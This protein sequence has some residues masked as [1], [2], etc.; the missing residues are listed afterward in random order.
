MTS[1]AAHTIPPHRR[2]R[3]RRGLIMPLVLIAMGISMILGLAFLSGAT[4]AS[5]TASAAAVWLNARMIA[6]SGI[7]VAL[8]QMD[9][10]P[11][12]RILRPNGTW[13]AAQPLGGGTF[14][15]TVQ[16]GEQLDAAGNV[17][18]DGSLSDD[19]QDPVVITCVATVGDTRYR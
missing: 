4:T 13:V 18:G 7:A 12:W 11:A 17:I 9:A 10:E 2:P 19:N 14:S 1:T 6:E 8:A 3:R 16:D 5:V 15:V